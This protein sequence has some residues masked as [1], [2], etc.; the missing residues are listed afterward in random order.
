V[1]VVVASLGLAGGAGARFI[2]WASA[3]ELPPRNAPAVNFRSDGT[4]LDLTFTLAFGGFKNGFAPNA[5][6]ISLWFEDWQ[7]LGYA[8]HL[9][10]FTYFFG[11]KEVFDNSVFAAG[12][13]MYLWIYNKPPTASTSEWALITDDSSDGASFDNWRFPLVTGS[14]GEPTV[15]F[16]A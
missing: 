1:G 3:P 15:S 13:Q 4:A 10:E 12:Q 7:P 16:R 5:G 6:N 14:P 8:I 11:E 2:D 9:P